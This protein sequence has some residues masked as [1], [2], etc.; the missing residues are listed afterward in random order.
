M[1]P[2]FSYSVRNNENS[3]I[4]SPNLEPLAPFRA[5][6]PGYIR[7]S[8]EHNIWQHTK[9]CQGL[10]Q[11]VGRYRK[12]KKEIP[13]DKIQ[14]TVE[15]GIE[16]TRFL[17]ASTSSRNRPHYSWKSGCLLITAWAQQSPLSKRLQL[18]QLWL[19]EELW[20]V[21]LEKKCTIIWCSIFP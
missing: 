6:L 21:K 9:I 14:F 5:D 7:S 17:V 4:P 3:Q 1:R 15:L 8:H 12:E 16:I 10:I 18:R 11:V 13:L 2:W 19:L 20:L